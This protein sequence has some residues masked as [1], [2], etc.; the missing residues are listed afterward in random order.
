MDLLKSSLL[1]STFIFLA[2]CGGS[3]GSGQTQSTEE[4]ASTGSAASETSSSI[5]EAAPAPSL[6]EDSVADS[7]NEIVV[8][9]LIV[10]HID[11]LPDPG[12]EG[13]Q[14]SMVV[15]LENTQKLLGIAFGEDLLSAVQNLPCEHGFFSFFGDAGLDNHCQFLGVTIL[16]TEEFELADSASIQ[17]SF[18]FSNFIASSGSTAYRVNGGES[19]ALSQG[20]AHTE[21]LSTMNLLVEDT[22]SE[23]SVWFKDFQETAIFDELN[24]AEIIFSGRIYLSD[25]G[26]VDVNT[27]SALRFQIMNGEFSLPEMGGEIRFEG[28]GSS[29]AIITAFSTGVTL[30]IDEDGDGVF[31]A[32]ENLSFEDVGLF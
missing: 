30:E 18:Q 25:L 24:Q 26:Y 13:L 19:Y 7:L 2:A 20:V 10:D 28:Q 32:V 15:N 8:P 16:H 3:G 12:Y 29:H 9:V 1:I 14:A 27:P 23:E 31:E 17:G 5:V 6:I 11:A 4:T 21:V 22:G